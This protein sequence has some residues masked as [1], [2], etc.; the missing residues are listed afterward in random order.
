MPARATAPTPK[1]ARQAEPGDDPSALGPPANKG[2]PAKDADGSVMGWI[3][4]LPKRFQSHRSEVE[5]ISRRSEPANGAAHEVEEGVS[6]ELSNAQ[7]FNP[8][9]GEVE[10]NL[11][12]ARQVFAE[13][14]GSLSRRREMLS[15]TYDEIERHTRVRK[16]FL[17]ALEEGAMEDLPSPVQ[18]RGILANYAAFL[19]LDVDAILLRFADG[20]QARHREQRQH[21]PGRSRAPM[22]VNTSLPPLRSFIASDLLFGGGVAIM[23]LLFAVWGINRVIS[24]RAAAP[25]GATAPSISDVLVGTPMPTLAQEVTLIPAAGGAVATDVASTPTVEAPTLAANI[26]V[27]VNLAASARTFMRVIVDGKV[28]FDG[29]TEPDQTYTYQAAKSVEV[30]TGNAGALQATYNGHDL[31]FLGAFG[32]VID[33]VYTAQGVV[34]PTSTPAPTRT[35][36]P[37]VTPTPT[38]TPTRTPTATPKPTAGG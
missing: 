28:Q 13:I 26:T 3:A 32:D 21:T 22:T 6:S 16:S 17:K 23:L 38:E 8:L 36:T 29:R 35:P 18:T 15:L 14:G 12:A 5:R 4:S 37:K 20:L 30:L 31:G 11:E 1:E 7:D 24:I 2:Q 10:G 25:V 27:Q 34:T 9:R 19:D 33:L